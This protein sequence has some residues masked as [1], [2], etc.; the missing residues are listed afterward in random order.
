MAQIIG[1]KPL[2][3]PGPETGP[4]GMGYGATLPT[5]PRPIPVPTNGS[6]TAQQAVISTRQAKPPN[7][8]GIM[9]TNIAPN[10][11]NGVNDWE[12]SAY[13]DMRSVLAAQTISKTA[14]SAVVGVLYSVADHSGWSDGSNA[15]GATIEYRTMTLGRNAAGDDTMVV[16]DVLSSWRH[17]GFHG[18]FRT[19]GHWTNNT[20]V[21]GIITMESEQS[22]T[23]SDPRHSTGGPWLAGVSM[24]AS[25][26]TIGQGMRQ[27]GI[28]ASVLV[29]LGPQY[30]LSFSNLQLQLGGCW[31]PESTAG[32]CQ[33][34]TFSGDDVT[35]IG[36]DPVYEQRTA[37]AY[38]VGYGAVTTTANY[39]HPISG[40]TGL[41]GG[42]PNPLVD[43]LSAIPL[44]S[45]TALIHYQDRRDVV[46]Q[47]TYSGGS[48]S[49]AMWRCKVSVVGPGQI[50]AYG[51]EK[52]DTSIGIE[53]VSWFSHNLGAISGQWVKADDGFMQ[54]AHVRVLR[55]YAD[56]V[57][58]YFDHRPI[59]LCYD[60]AGNY[61][62]QRVFMKR[63]A[64]YGQEAGDPYPWFAGQQYQFG[65]NFVSGTVLGTQR[66]WGQ[67]YIYNNDNNYGDA[68]RALMTDFLSH[69]DGTFSTAPGRPTVQEF[70]DV[71]ASY[72]NVHQSVDIFQ[73][74]RFSG[75]SRTFQSILHPAFPD[76]MITLNGAGRNQLVLNE[77]NGEYYY[78]SNYHSDL[79]AMIIK[80]AE[81]TRHPGLNQLVKVNSFGEVTKSF[82]VLYDAYNATT[83]QHLEYRPSN[84]SVSLN[85]DE[86]VVATG[87]T[88]YKYNYASGALLASASHN[89]LPDNI[90]RVAAGR[91]KVWFSV[92]DPEQSP[93]TKLYSVNLDSLGGLLSYETTGE[94]SAV[95]VYQDT[96]YYALRNETLIV[97][98]PGPYNDNQSWEWKRV[99]YAATQMYGLKSIK[100]LGNG[101]MG[102]LNGLLDFTDTGKVPSDTAGY[103]QSTDT[104]AYQMSSTSVAIM[105]GTAA[106]VWERN[107]IW[108]TGRTQSTSSIYDYALGRYVYTTTYFWRF[109][110]RKHATPTTPAVISEF[111]MPH[112]S[113]PS[114]IRTDVEMWG[115]DSP[116]TLAVRNKPNITQAGKGGD[117]KFVPWGPTP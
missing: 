1:Y 65:L 81:V 26:C 113:I 2:T 22:G 11:A 92:G 104:L 29:R 84:P 44:S 32:L 40:D 58:A 107:D 36:P 20:S 86:I 35:H 116:A 7:H 15:P 117:R 100:H 66:F 33:V 98:G 110:F 79:V 62:G 21:Q 80:P 114:A 57:T 102:S 13:R 17:A 28:D 18:S 3:Q 77:Y 61:V 76:R 90:Y 48:P 39:G 91:T 16:S 38:D 89:S 9:V 19:Y 24:S 53:Y 115:I 94:I 23:Y 56:G 12:G 75:G 49:F 42:A 14:N 43:C 74:D 64:Y 72:V 55:Y 99:N 45:T 5:Q 83:K 31:D 82:G 51:H 103:L 37:R 112:P 25:G 95:T 78:G 70:L 71:P 46:A 87:K 27:T 73:L 54:M 88:L 106:S 69:P 96:P 6:A 4:N 93:G 47:P 34:I 8:V 59:W 85:K 108:F 63:W 41:W 67:A 30:A 60:M 68:S 97:E 10:W 109:G 101:I 52:L 105:G 50:M 111:Y